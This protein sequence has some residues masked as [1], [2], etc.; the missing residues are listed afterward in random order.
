MNGL[1]F[2][3]LL[4]QFLGVC[5]RRTAQDGENA[6]QRKHV[7]K[8]LGLRHRRAPGWIVVGSSPLTKERRLCFSISKNLTFPAM[9]KHNLR[10]MGRF[11]FINRLVARV[12]RT[13]AT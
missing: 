11:P 5:G 8:E 6:D 1:L 12:F 4:A 10:D 9:L 13:D 2:A 3:A 7:A